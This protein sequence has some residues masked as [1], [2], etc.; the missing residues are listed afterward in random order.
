MGTSLQYL[1]VAVSF[2]GLGRLASATVVLAKD[3][4]NLKTAPKVGL[5]TVHV[6]LL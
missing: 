1:K 6:L 2:W 4:F 3:K 5:P